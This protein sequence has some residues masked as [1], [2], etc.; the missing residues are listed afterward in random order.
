MKVVKHGQIPNTWD[1]SW[2]EV[3]FDVYTNC[4]ITLSVSI[5]GGRHYSQTLHVDWFEDASAT[6]TEAELM[7]A[8]LLEEEG[9]QAFD[10][11]E[12]IE[13]VEEVEAIEDRWMTATLD[14]SGKTPFFRVKIDD[15][16]P[17]EYAVIV[18]GEV[19]EIL[20]LIDSPK[21]NT[22]TNPEAYLALLEDLYGKNLFAA[23]RGDELRI[24]ALKNGLNIVYAYCFSEA[25]LT[26]A[27]SADD[28][29]ENYT[30]Y[31]ERADG[32]VEAYNAMDDLDYN[33]SVFYVERAGSGGGVIP[34]GGGSSGSGS[35]GGGST[36]APTPASETDMLTEA[37]KDAL[38]GQYG[39]LEQNAWSRDGVAYVLH[40]GI[41]NGMGDGSF[42]P[43]IPTSRA[44]I[45]TMLYR[46]EK[47]PAVSGALT[48]RDVP[49]GQWYTDAI[50]WATAQGIVNGY[51]D[52]AF[53]PNDNVSREQ[54]AT[55]LYRYARYKGMDVSAET[56]LSGFS[57]A[58]TVS[59]WATDA[60][61]WTVSNGI[62]NG[63]GNN[64]LS[65]G[66]EAVRAQVA[67]MLMRY[68]ALAQ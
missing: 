46:M 40:K 58:G 63:T 6:L 7:D 42:G 12:E 14:E 50:R 19:E 41:M 35:S 64:I 24:P 62:I 13:E 66:A 30:Y 18:A 47:E 3:T 68:D 17:K 36:P 27:L 11:F 44:M 67:T 37:E 39:D 60:L 34:T 43:N 61:R 15:T 25:D 4:D 9:P 21:Y 23:K 49:G 31:V 5:G 2:Y 55:I 20:E 51:S 33:L 59:D 52:T 32:T 56:T 16:A 54:L 48:F 53:G 57:D 28:D 22:A 26:A 65:P 29:Y 10:T 45:V 8:E 38:L 1:Y